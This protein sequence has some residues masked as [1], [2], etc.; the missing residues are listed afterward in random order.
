M[1]RFNLWMGI[2]DAF[3][4]LVEVCC[5]GVLCFDVVGGV[6]DACMMFVM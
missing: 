3:V 1:L 2:S 4:L 5:V 6:Q